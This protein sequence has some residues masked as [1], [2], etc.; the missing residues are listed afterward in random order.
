MKLFDQIRKLASDRVWF[1]PLVSALFAGV[2]AALL[3]QITV[4]TDSV[5]ATYLW[6][7]DTAAAADMLSFIASSM[8]TVLTTVISM[9]LIVL[10]VASGQ[11]SQQLLRDYIRS[12]AV[13]GIFSV[14]TAV[15]V[16]A[17]ILLR[18]VEAEGI[19]TPP[20]IGV[21]LAMILVLAALATFV[22]YV[23]RVVAMVRVD[24]IIESVTRSV[25]SLYHRHQK[26]WTEK[27]DAPKV[28]ENAR[29]LRANDAGFIRII[30]LERGARWAEEH[31]AC[32]VV[33]VA[34]GD[35]VV[36]G[37]PLAWVWGRD[38]E[39]DEDLELPGSVVHID[40]ERASDADIRLGVHQLSDIAVRA[41]SPGT[42]DPTTAVH[43]VNQAISTLRMIAEEPMNN[44]AIFDDD[45]NLRAFAPAP[46]TTDFV[47][48]IVGPVRRYSGAEPLV[49]IQL[50]RLLAVVEEGAVEG[51]VA[52]VVAEE[53][54]RIIEQA[55]QE[56]P[57]PDD[58]AWVR[59]MSD[60]EAIR[61]NL[62]VSGP[63]IDLVD[64]SEGKEGK[65][66][67]AQSD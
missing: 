13:K 32:F 5:L 51:D 22:W 57:H 60:I 31:D 47:D 18:S 17:I 67:N 37:Q 64:S 59:K 2:A 12:N 53:R 58:A 10:Q 38:G 4:P 19:E 49:L 44:E 61:S 14:F 9:T 41:M 30:L 3:G 42:N 24:S 7:G 6:P 55:E 39:L 52:E 48:E 20:Q 16:Y 46:S 62:R 66:S 21:T 11:F 33:A 8:L 28:P 25:E 26:K 27:V 1:V 45:G 54:K 36:T 63:K 50:L 23:A 34:P 40:Y 29:A 65:D 56:M 35:T 43:A 15:F